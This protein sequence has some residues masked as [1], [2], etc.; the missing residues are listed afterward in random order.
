MRYSRKVGNSENSGFSGTAYFPKRI[1]NERHE[2]LNIYALFYEKAYAL[3]ISYTKGTCK[4][5]NLT[6]IFSLF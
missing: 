2:K 1:N 3:S 4:M 6:Y 5:Y